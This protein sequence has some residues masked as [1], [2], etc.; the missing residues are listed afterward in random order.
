MKAKD[1]QTVFDIAIENSGSVDAAFDIAVKNNISISGTPPANETLQKSE[2][3]DRKVTDYMNK[4]KVT[5][6]TG[7]VS[8]IT[9][10]RGIGNMAIGENFR[11]S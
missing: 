6:V 10:R 1:N 4:N 3:T 7:A 8:E 9:R 2:V 11:V 5:P